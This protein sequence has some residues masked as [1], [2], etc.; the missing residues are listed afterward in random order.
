MCPPYRFYHSTLANSLLQPRGR[1]LR[2]TRQRRRDINRLNFRADFLLSLQ[3]HSLTPKILF[4]IHTHSHATGSEGKEQRELTFVTTSLLRPSHPFRFLIALPLRM[5][6]V[7]IARTSAAPC[8][9]TV[10]AAL[11]S[12]PA[13]SHMSSI[14]MEILPE[15]LP[16]RTC[17]EGQLGES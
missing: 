5:P 16:T 11:H 8:S 4:S 6:C 17:G 12:V 3:R 2:L 14:R 10:E 9:F 1:T 15:T 13:V 7:H